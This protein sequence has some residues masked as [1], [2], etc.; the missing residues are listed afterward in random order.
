MS[1]ITV[2]ISTWQAPFDQ[3][4]QG[5]HQ[6]GGDNAAQRALDFINEQS[7]AW[8][9]ANDGDRSV[10]A[11]YLDTNDH[12]EGGTYA[13][14]TELGY[15]HARY[16]LWGGEAGFHALLDQASYA[17]LCEEHYVREF[18]NKGVSRPGYL[19]NAY[20][21]GHKSDGITEAEAEK[22]AREQAEG[23]AAIEAFTNKH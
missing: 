8:W 23:L 10:T 16:E 12:G 2:V 18:D 7:A 13:P 6:F 15:N 4:V 21:A 5:V 14:I 1:L 9:A 3:V 22:Y 11:G 19:I 17:R 20:L